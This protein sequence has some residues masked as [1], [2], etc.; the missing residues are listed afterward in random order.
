MIRLDKTK[1]LVMTGKITLE[2][3]K[4]VTI[5]HFRNQKEILFV[6]GVE[7]NWCYFILAFMLQEKYLS[8]Y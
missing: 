4:I 8:I 6:R 3:K 1:D 5:T 2:M 7:R